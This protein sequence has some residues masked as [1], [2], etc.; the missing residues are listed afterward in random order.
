MSA[1]LAKHIN[2]RALY[3]RQVP[4][5]TDAKETIKHIAFAHRGCNFAMDQ[6]INEQYIYL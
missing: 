2:V 3:S 5:N 4:G 6:T 1:Q